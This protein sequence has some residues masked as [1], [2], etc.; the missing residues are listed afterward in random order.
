MSQDLNPLETLMKSQAQ[1]STPHLALSTVSAVVGSVGSLQTINNA[2]STRGKVI[3]GV[4]LATRVS[5]GALYAKT[6]V[7]RTKKSDEFTGAALNDDMQLASNAVASLVALAI[8]GRRATNGRS[9]FA[10]TTLSGARRAESV[11][12]S[13][14][15]VVLLY[16][17][18]S[19]LYARHSAKMQQQIAMA[20]LVGPMVVKA[21]IRELKS[22]IRP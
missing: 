12:D 19:T 11:V 7:G 10:K 1:K 16:D 20:Q 18:V 6:F 4:G 3:A 14:A 21:K 8:S 9:L 13:A 2:T 17:S 15:S 22:K 5:Y